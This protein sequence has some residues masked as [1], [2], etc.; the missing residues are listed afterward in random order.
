[1]QS[2]LTSNVINMMNTKRLKVVFV[3]MDEPFYTPIYFNNF[4]R[5][6][7]ETV[8]VKKVYALHPHLANKS[9]F[10]T[11]LDFLSYF[12]LIVFSYMVILRFCYLLG[13][14]FN[15][16][17]KMGGQLH[18]VELVCRKYGISCSKTNKINAENVLS[19][20]REL[21]P[22]I[23]FSVASPQIFKKDLISIPSKG[24]LNIHSS[25]LPDYRGQDANFWVLAKGEK[26]SGVTIHYLSPGI[27][28]GDIVL[29]EK[30]EIES[31]WSLRDLYLKA[32]EVGSRL[33]VKSLQAIHEGQV[34]AQKNDISKGSYFSFPTSKDVKE[35][36]SRQRRFF[37]YY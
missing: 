13:D 31:D 11:A 14:L 21:E 37:K 28:D 24:C 25:L 8:E 1:M 7:P 19:E 36:R 26:V 18:S 22:D 29:Q 17:F 30:I 9:F 16:Y 15:Q 6:L 32:I 4:L 27:D 10:R 12:G 23:I 35:F 3:T 20:L 2:D 5:A 33:I 34:V